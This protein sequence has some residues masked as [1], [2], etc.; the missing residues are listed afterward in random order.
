MSLEIAHRTPDREREKT[1]GQGNLAYTLL[2]RQAGDFRVSGRAHTTHVH[3]TTISIATQV[4]SGLPVRKTK[5]GRG[6]AHSVPQ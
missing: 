5:R 1:G 3:F 4:L 2:P 6:K